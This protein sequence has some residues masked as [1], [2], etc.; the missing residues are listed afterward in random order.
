MLAPPRTL[1]TA[2]QNASN[3][4]GSERILLDR[5]FECSP[6]AIVLADQESRVVRINAGFNRLFGYGADEARGRSLDELLA[7]PDLRQEAVD[8]TTKVA[9][10]G[11]VAF[12]TR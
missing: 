6:E 10:G 3:L 11:Q 12:E 8:A 5:L 2:D 9:R 4:D 1:S 7:P